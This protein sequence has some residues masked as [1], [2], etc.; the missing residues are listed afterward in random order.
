[1]YMRL[2]HGRPKHARISTLAVA[3]PNTG[4]QCLTAIPASRLAG[5]RPV[6]ACSRRLHMETST[7][8]PS[9][10][11]GDSAMYKP[12]FQAGGC[13]YI[14]GLNSARL[15]AY[16][17]HAASPPRLSVCCLSVLSC[18]ARSPCPRWPASPSSSCCYRWPSKA[19]LRHDQRTVMTGMTARRYDA[20]EVRQAEEL[21]K[22]AT[23][24]PQSADG[25]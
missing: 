4:G 15:P 17:R 5:A 6:N 9:I 18:R 25:T 23:A 8:V 14:V 3:G 11:L 21:V 10:S 1:M 24:L 2:A 20:S 19:S 16:G 22:S 12:V 7:T 13:L